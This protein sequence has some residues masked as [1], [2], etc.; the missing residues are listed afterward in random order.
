MR[1]IM[2]LVRSMDIVV[3]RWSGRIIVRTPAV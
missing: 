3:V 2:R 1:R